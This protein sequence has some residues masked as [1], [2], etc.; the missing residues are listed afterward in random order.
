MS[1]ACLF[2]D[3]RGRS[4][5]DQG[6]IRLDRNPQYFEPL[7]GYMRDGTFILNPGLSARGKSLLSRPAAK[8]TQTRPNISKHCR[9]AC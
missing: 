5:D 6:A 1:G 3:V 4:L 7:L 2:A 8:H 9:C